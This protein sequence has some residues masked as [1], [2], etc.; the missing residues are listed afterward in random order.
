MAYA[1]G[2][3]LAICSVN[4]NMVRDEIDREVIIIAQGQKQDD[5]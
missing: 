3:G 4:P 5:A 1:A 2:A